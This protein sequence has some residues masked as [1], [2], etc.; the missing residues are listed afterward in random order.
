MEGK[1]ASKKHV[2]ELYTPG[3]MLGKD[4]MEYTYSRTKN[5]KLKVTKNG[6]F[7]QAEQGVIKEHEHL[8]NDALFKDA[9]KKALLL[10]L[11]KY[12]TCI[13]VKTLISSVDGT[14]K[15]ILD[16][17][18]ESIVYSLCGLKLIRKLNLRWDNKA[19]SKTVL[20]TPK[21][22]YDRRFAATFALMMSNSKQYL[23]ERFL[24]L[25]MSMNGLYGYIAEIG[26][27]CSTGRK[28][29]WLGKEYAQLKLLSLCMNYPYQ[30]DFVVDGDNKSDRVMLELEKICVTIPVE[31]T[32]AFLLSCKHNDSQNTYVAKIKD[33]LSEYHLENSMH[34]YPLILIWLSYQIRCKYF[35]AEN[36]LPLLCFKDEHPL[37]A[38]RIC[39][40]FMWDFLD[41]NLADW[42]IDNNREMAINE[43]VTAIVMNG[44]Y[45][46]HCDIQ[47]NIPLNI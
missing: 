10:Q 30:A 35:H 1:M 47:C 6:F 17:V 24:Y 38:L 21:S 12:G 44:D 37:P 34:P 29:R 18:N 13:E 8:L 32:E 25:W 15:I 41:K 46:D 36:A 31:E 43:L 3:C 4:Y 2:Y 33:L 5:I 19:I 7:V 23:T 11:L 28:K 39:C 9:I 26:R 22:R 45:F 40:H 14:T 20:D 42:F 16:N 27:N